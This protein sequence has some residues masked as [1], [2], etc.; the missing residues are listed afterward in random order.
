MYSHSP[1]LTSPNSPIA[2]LHVVAELLPIERPAVAEALEVAD[3][4]QSAAVQERS[5][6]V[7][8]IGFS[9]VPCTFRLQVVRFTAGEA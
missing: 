2:A 6:Y 5:S 9:G 1:W 4:L 3:R 7:N 8:S